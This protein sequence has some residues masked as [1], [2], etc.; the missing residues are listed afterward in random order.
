MSAVEKQ[1]SRVPVPEGKEQQFIAIVR[2]LSE[3]FGVKEIPGVEFHLD[4][5]TESV[6]RHLFT[7]THPFENR[8]K[9]NSQRA[10]FLQEFKE[11]YLV[12]TD[13]NYRKPVLSMDFKQI[14]SVIELLNDAN[15]EITDYLAWVFDEFL[16]QNPKLSPPYI[17][18]VCGSLFMDKFLFEH[19]EQLRSKKEEMVKQEELIALYER[20]RVVARKVGKPEFAEKVHN[21]LKEFKSGHIMTIAEFRNR[22]AEFETM[23]KNG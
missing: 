2:I 18:G 5:L 4:A 6:E 17:R 1:P 13:F 22:I 12:L 7:K 19:K 16:P 10:R 15:V 20:A 21:T 9:S 11:R 23:A 14:D 8:R 3:Q